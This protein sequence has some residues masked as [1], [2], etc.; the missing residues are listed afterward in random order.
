MKTIERALNKA[1]EESGI[2][3]DYQIEELLSE[4][5]INHSKDVLQRIGMVELSKNFQK[6]HKTKKELT[7]LSNKNVYSLEQIKKVARGYDLKF[8]HVSEFIGSI[9]MDFSSVVGNYLENNEPKKCFIRDDS[10][11]RRQ[12]KYA[13]KEAPAFYI[14][15]PQE[16]FQKPVSITELIPSK[17]PLLFAQLTENTFYLVHQWGKDISK[18][19]YFFSQIKRHSFKKCISVPFCLAGVTTWVSSCA[20]EN[21]QTRMFLF[22]AALGLTGFAFMIHPH[23]SWEQDEKDEAMI[24]V[25]PLV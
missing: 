22:I 11:T 7:G 6:E 4:T 8:S 9:P 23:K 5:E 1:K 20:C 12:Q 19:R 18:L 21:E 2:V 24:T 14:L 15:A 16:A 17:D 3:S 10:E 13:T 25:Y